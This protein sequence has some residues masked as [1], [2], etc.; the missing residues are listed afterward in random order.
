MVMNTYI[1]TWVNLESIGATWISWIKSVNSLIIPSKFVIDT[2]TVS[3][4]DVKYWLHIG[5]QCL[6][7]FATNLMLAYLYTREV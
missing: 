7:H 4:M 3:L 6:V 1:K 2:K 5:N